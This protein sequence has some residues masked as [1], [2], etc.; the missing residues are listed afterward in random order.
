M[1]ITDSGP[2]IYV[3][4][5]SNEDNLYDSDNENIPEGTEDEGLAASGQQGETDQD[6]ELVPIANDDESAMGSRGGDLKWVWDKGKEGAVSTPAL[7]D[8]D[9]DGFLEVIFVTTGDQII[10]LNHDGSKRQINENYIIEPASYFQQE[11]GLDFWPVNLFS[12][13]TPANIDRDI[14]PELILGA[15]NGLVFLNHDLEPKYSQAHTGRYYFSTPVVTDLEGDYANIDAEGNKI[16]HYKDLEI[17]TG[18]DDTVP[19]AYFEAWHATGGDVFDVRSVE[20]GESAFV[21]GIAVGELSGTMEDDVYDEADK[22]KAWMEIVFAT[23]DKGMRIFEKTGKQFSSDHNHEHPVYADDTSFNIRG[24]LSYATPAVGDFSKVINPGDPEKLEII[25]G[26]GGWHG[27]NPP[28]YVVTNDAGLFCYDEDGTEHWRAMEEIVVV[29][30]PAVADVQTIDRDEATKKDAEYEIFAANGHEGEVYSID[31]DDGTVLWSWQ[32]DGAKSEENRVL[33][34]PA[35]ANI[36]SDDELEVIFGSDNGKVYAFDGDPSDGNND[37]YEY[38]KYSGEGTSQFDLLWEFDTHE[39]GGTGKIGISSPV[40]ADIDKDGV[41]EVVIGD[42]T[43]KV[44]CIN[45]GGTASRGQQDWTMFHYDVN[46]SGFYDPKLSYSVDIRPYRDPYDQTLVKRET[47]VEPLQTA[48][49]KLTVV[50]TGRGLSM[51][52][53]DNIYIS[54]YVNSENPNPGWRYTVEGNEIQKHDDMQ[55]VKLNMQDSTVIEL[56]VTAPP[57]GDMGDYISIIIKVNSSFDHN[58]VDSIELFTFLHIK[59]DFNLEFNWKVQSDP[60]DI[61]FNK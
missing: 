50:N 27:R 31:A 14:R 19:H 1:V 18:S 59:V 28:Y 20:G 38:S 33:S 32:I 10:A 17:L 54:T 43:G 60:M 13:I 48:N 51:D 35:I 11:M 46:N 5:N 30:S 24:H 16:S 57:S 9:A 45:A 6:A 49:F 23:H 56:N 34:S 61:Y 22:E 47:Y 12:S 44:W 55:Y 7:V 29:S 53:Y 21:L 37:G 40:V 39:H 58:A 42:S 8:L 25:V 3:Q 4:Y 36:N 52:D 26:K 2:Q 15:Y 41:L